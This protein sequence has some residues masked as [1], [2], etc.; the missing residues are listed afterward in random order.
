MLRNS[1]IS[2]SIASLGYD[3]NQST[4][5]IEFL[6]GAVYQYHNIPTAVY[7]SF[8]NANSC[9]RYFNAHIK[10]HYKYNKAC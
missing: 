10:P 1:I 2:T 3:P 9:G 8:V 6:E 5:E 7:L 4:L